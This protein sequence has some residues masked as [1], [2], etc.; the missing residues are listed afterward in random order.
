[1][2]DKVKLLEDTA[3]PAP[4]AAPTGIA[5]P[6]DLRPQTHA[7]TS[8]VQFGNADRLG[9]LKKPLPSEPARQRSANTLWPTG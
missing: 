1:M 7:G 8:P 6:G 3:A 4:P 5:V 2:R 9:I